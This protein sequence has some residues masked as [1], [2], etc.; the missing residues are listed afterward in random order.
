MTHTFESGVF[1][2]GFS[3]GADG[4]GGVAMAERPLEIL[5]APVVVAVAAVTSR[6]GVAMGVCVS[7]DGEVI[8][9]WTS[10]LPSPVGR[11]LVPKSC[12]D[13]CPCLR[14]GSETLTLAD[15]DSIS[16]PIPPNPDEEYSFEEECSCN[17]GNTMDDVGGTPDIVDRD[18]R[19]CR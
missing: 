11:R 8:I 19:R 2:K 4:G 7:V 12:P 3:G 6:G 17:P 9:S 14:P 16:C 15:S 18:D 1:C 5:P 10:L 13:F